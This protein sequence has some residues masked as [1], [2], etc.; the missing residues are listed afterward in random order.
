LKKLR[1]AFG[2]SDVVL[3]LSHYL[4]DLFKRLQL[5][6][7]PTPIKEDIETKL[8]TTRQRVTEIMQYPET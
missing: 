2:L 4:P 8:H 1:K 5:P 6:V 7:Q 3:I